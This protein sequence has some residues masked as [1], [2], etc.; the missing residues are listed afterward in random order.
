MVFTCT[1]F[2]KFEN[3]VEYRYLDVKWTIFLKFKLPEV[4]INLHFVLFELV[5]ISPTP[6][7][8]WRKQSKC[9]FNSDRRFKLRRIR[10]IRVRDSESRLYIN[11]PSGFTGISL[12][13]GLL[14]CWSAKPCGLGFYNLQFGLMN[15]PP[16]I[17][18]SAKFLVCFNF[19]SATKLPKVGLNVV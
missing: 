12:V 3:T 11:S 8:C 14:V 15:L 9:I 16:K 4:Q 10:D 13:V 7:F 2:K 1:L 18:L 19:K 5:N 17:L 6:I